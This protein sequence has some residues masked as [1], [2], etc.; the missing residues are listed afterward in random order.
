MYIWFVSV[1][2]TSNGNGRLSPFLQGYDWLVGNYNHTAT[3]I[4]AKQ[5]MNTNN[6][7]RVKKKKTSILQKKYMLLFWTTPRRNS[8]GSKV[9]R[10]GSMFVGL[11]GWGLAACR[12]LGFISVIHPLV[13]RYLRWVSLHET[14]HVVFDVN[15]Y[16]SWRTRCSISCWQSG[17]KSMNC[18]S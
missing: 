1:S 11:L 8:S 2:R 12:R 15:I 9:R 6:D 7:I 17:Y 16:M 18:F 4:S 14:S 10:T 3:K 5:I 13:W